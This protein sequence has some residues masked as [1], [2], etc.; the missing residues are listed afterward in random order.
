MGD[1]KNSQANISNLENINLKIN[2]N[3]FEIQLIETINWFKKEY[4]KFKIREY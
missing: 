1:I 2:T 3:K 4:G